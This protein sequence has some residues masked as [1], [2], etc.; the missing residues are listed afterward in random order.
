ML[1]RLK[2]NM[3]SLQI[4]NDSV[5]ATS[6]ISANIYLCKLDVT[7][8]GEMIGKRLAAFPVTRSISQGLLGFVG[9]W[10]T[11]IEH[12]GIEAVDTIVNIFVKQ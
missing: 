8:E 12:A 10:K 9:G 5:E 2:I 11:V 3:L 1:N 4:L 7:A 6:Y